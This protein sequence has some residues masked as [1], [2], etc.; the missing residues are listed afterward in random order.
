MSLKYEHMCTSLVFIQCQQHHRIDEDLYEI[1]PKWHLQFVSF[2]ISNMYMK[3]TVNE[4]IN[5]KTHL[6]LIQSIITSFKLFTFGFTLI[7][8]FVLQSYNVYP[9]AVP[10]IFISAVSFLLSCC[11]IK[12]QFSHPCRSVILLLSN[13]KNYSLLLVLNAC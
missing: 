8:L 10:N 1:P 2:Y 3:I 4:L 9:A 11:F 7:S 13:F 12:F 6:T 5:I